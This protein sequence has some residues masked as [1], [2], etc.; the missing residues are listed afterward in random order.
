[1]WDIS[2]N[3]SLFEMRFAGFVSVRIAKLSPS[4]RYAALLML[5]RNA[6]N[7]LLFVD[8]RSRTVSA[9]HCFPSPFPFNDLCFVYGQ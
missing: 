1:M 6:Q 7:Y 3:T 8:L 9:L 5:A 2:T 4:N